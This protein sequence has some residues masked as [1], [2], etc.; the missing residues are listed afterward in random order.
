MTGSQPDRHPRPTRRRFLV[1]S[2]ASMGL[3]LAGCL[4]D[5]PA[6][7]ADGDGD[8]S[9]ETTVFP[10]L[11]L[12]GEALTPTFPFRL[13]EPAD[14]TVVA[15]VHWHG[16]DFSHWHFAPLEVPV[17]DVRVLEVLARN[18]DQEQLP[19]GPEGYG[20]TVRRT[21]DTAEDLLSVRAAQN[22]V[23]FHGNSPGTGALVFGLVDDGEGVWTSPPL[24]TVVE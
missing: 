13:L 24:E 4:D 20:V 8:N 15:E 10:G 21:I 16:P 12:N 6:E 23:E 5:E 22:V 17:E 19:L 11:E 7:I 2:A 1:G 3:L 14:D 9:E 18:V